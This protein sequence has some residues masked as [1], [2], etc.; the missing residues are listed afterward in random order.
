MAGDYESK[1]FPG[2]QKSAS[3]I[4]INEKHIRLSTYIAT[5]TTFMTLKYNL[6][7]S[8]IGTEIVGSA[9]VEAEAVGRRVLH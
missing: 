5:K 3:Y 7:I 4:F 9:L 2:Q 6:P 1:R 8:N